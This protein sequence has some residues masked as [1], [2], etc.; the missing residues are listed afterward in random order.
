MQEWGD[1]RFFLATAR[2]GS[3]LSAAR[4]LGVNQT[5]VARRIAALESALSVKLFDRNKD[6][7]ALTKDAAAILSQVERIEAEVETLERIAAQRNRRSSNVIRVT[8]VQDVADVVLTPWL[9][10]FIDLHPN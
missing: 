1:L 9:A 10:E 5:T 3:T 8:P 7:Y 2:R 4:D 6:G